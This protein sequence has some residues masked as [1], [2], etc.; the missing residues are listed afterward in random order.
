VRLWLPVAV[1]VFGSALIGTAACVDGGAPTERS[2]EI[3]VPRPGPREEIC[4]QPIEW[5]QGE[6]VTT[7][8]GN[9]SETVSV[10]RSALAQVAATNPY[11]DKAATGDIPLVVDPGC[12]YLPLPYSSGLKWAGYSPAEGR[13]APSVKIS[14]RYLLFLYILPSE[15][16]IEELL[17]RPG[18]RRAVQEM[19]C[20]NQDGGS[21]VGTAAPGCE[22]C[23]TTVEVTK[24]IYLTKDEVA[25]GSPV[26]YELI[27]SGF[28]LPETR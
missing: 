2:E 20:Q 8:F 23:R 3:R 12:P 9:A 25:T 10:V 7:N 24:A 16:D 21:C 11:W 15:S 1:V 14:S 18:A 6:I 13:A 4:V 5:E 22:G 28:G 27:E 19:K 17:G 26:L